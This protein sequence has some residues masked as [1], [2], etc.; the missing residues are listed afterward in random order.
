MQQN[1][2]LSEFET[3]S[4]R[5]GSK[6][7]Y[8]G[9]SYNYKN[10]FGNVLTWRCSIRGCNGTLHTDELM[11]FKNC[12]LHNHLKNENLEIR[13]KGINEVKTRSLSTTELHEI[14]YLMFFL[15]VKMFKSVVVQNIY[16]NLLLR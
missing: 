12:N 5:G 3:T 6:I 10:A 16:R 1:I 13:R 15:P 11:N 4:K 8:D 2:N 14:L 7:V 9:Y